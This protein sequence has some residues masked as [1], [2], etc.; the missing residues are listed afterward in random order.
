MPAIG[1]IFGKPATLKTLGV[2]LLLLLALPFNLLAVFVACVLN[3]AWAPFRSPRAVAERPRRIMITGGKMTKA[4]QLARSF[5]AAGHD[6]ILVETHKYWLTGHRFS[7]AVAAFHT[8]PAPEEDP[9]A[10]CQALVAIARQEGVDTFIPV[11]SPVASYYD[12]LAKQALSGF[13]EA[14][15]FD[16]QATAML[17]DKYAFCKQARE[18]GL[19]APEVHRFTSPDRVLAF[20]FTGERRYILK[21]IPYDSVR[22]LDLTQLPFAGM[23]DYLRKLPMSEERPWVMQEFV[24]GREYCTHSTVRHG[25]IRLHCCSESS[26]FQVNYAHVDRPEILAWVEK[27]AREL[28]LTGQLSFDFIETSDGLV[29]PIECNPRTHSAITMFHNHPDLAAAYLEDGPEL[30]L[31]LPNSKPT[32]WL[33]HELWRLTQLR[34]W[35]DLGAWFEKLAT[36]VDAMYRLEDPL[37]FLMVHHW[38]IPLLLLEN[39]RRGRGWIRI[40]FNIG[41]LVELGGD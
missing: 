17:D 16:P 38:Q 28:D 37:P 35:S 18:I 32:Y 21:S 3:F 6:V 22:R 10:Y 27:F 26:P 23:E 15:H 41:K 7:R 1:L 24:R 2:L 9:K 13:C 30:V 11:A 36:G 31:P 4:L 14:V 12:S 34:S 33:Y 19:P 39:L 40:D 20:K 25:Q 29:F 8:V 5:Y